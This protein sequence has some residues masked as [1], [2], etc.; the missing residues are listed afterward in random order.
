[1]EALMS[2]GSQLY[3]FGSILVF[4]A[5]FY[6]IQVL[7]ER[8]AP[9]PKWFTHP[10]VFAGII[11]ALYLVG[12]IN[13]ALLRGL[14]GSHFVAAWVIIASLTLLILG[15]PLKWAMSLL[16]PPKKKGKGT[17]NVTEFVNNEL[18]WT[19]FR[20]V[21]TAIGVGLEFFLIGFVAWLLSLLIR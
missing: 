5:V 9:L 19:P 21:M 1:M 2:D 10:L 4:T 17:I 3:W 15:G 6:G 16:A 12:G 13:Y 18:V 7:V 14:F 8:D 11:G 20:F